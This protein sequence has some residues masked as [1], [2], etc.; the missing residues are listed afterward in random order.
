LS[1][2]KGICEYLHANIKKVYEKYAKYYE[3]KVMAPP[4]FKVGDLKRI[5]ARNMKTKRPSKKLDNKKIGPVKIV[6]KIGT[7]AFKVELPPS[8]QIHNVF[9]VSMLEPYR[10]SRHSN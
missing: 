3:P 10:T 8:M 9:H 4:G 5:D 6:K 2:W 7:R 1:R